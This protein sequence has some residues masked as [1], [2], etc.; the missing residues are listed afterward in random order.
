MAFEYRV[1]GW[2]LDFRVQSYG[3]RGFGVELVSSEVVAR[4]GVVVTTEQAC[5]RTFVILP[6]AVNI[7]S[8]MQP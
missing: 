1:E 3:D 2:G 7:M 6:L 5:S 8:S 4:I